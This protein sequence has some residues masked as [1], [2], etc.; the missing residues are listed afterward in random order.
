MRIIEQGDEEHLFNLLAYGLEE[1]MSCGEVRMTESFRRLG[2]RRHMKFSMGVSVESNLMD[3]R[4]LSED[5]SE[6]ELLNIFY[7]SHYY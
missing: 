2:L 1:L 4:V 7:Q 6:E 3:L 5:L